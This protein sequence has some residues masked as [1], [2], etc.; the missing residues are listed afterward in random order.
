MNKRNISHRVNN[1]KN[2]RNTLK[3]RKTKKGDLNSTT[4]HL[5]Q[6]LINGV[7]TELQQCLNMDIYQTG[8]HLL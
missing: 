8:I 3:N 7:N 5:R 6:L 2:A 1:R 4:K